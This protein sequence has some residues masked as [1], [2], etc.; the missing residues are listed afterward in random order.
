MAAPSGQKPRP[1]RAPG[2]EEG[3]GRTATRPHQIPASGWR[4]ILARIKQGL[5]DDHVS[6]VSA[7]VA[8][9]ALFALFPAL[10]AFVSIYG[11]I[12]DPTQVQ[13]QLSALS[14]LLPQDAYALVQQQLKNVASQAGGALT[15]GAIGAL[16]LAL[17]GA[18][19]GVKALFDALN[20]VYDEEENRSFFKL[21]ALALLLTVGAILFG[22]FTLILIAALPAVLGNLGLSELVRN[23]LSFGRWPLL[24]V[25][26][27]LALAVMYRFGPSREQPQW[28]WVTWGA[29]AA[30]LLWL[31]GSVAF[32][33]Y[34]SNFGSYDKTYGSMGAVVILLMW[35]YLSAYV[36]L[37][38][39]ELNAETEHQTTQDTTTGAPERLGRRGAHVADSVGER[40]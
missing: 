35:L 10:A 2:R 15:A 29:I 5:S 22:T 39:A 28:R 4:D 7:G 37:L 30:T 32:S 17:W 19:K 23:L 20:I 31:I 21:N 33:I 6:I 26:L 34:V 36:V 9:Y 3:R 11:L 12:T 25:V 38:G 14:S 27:M 8:F 1:N 13:Q 24:A 16:L 40:H 18:T